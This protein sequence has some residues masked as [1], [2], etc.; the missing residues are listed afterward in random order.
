M[1]SASDCTLPRVR[2]VTLVRAR[3]ASRAGLKL[4]EH[5]EREREG[6]RFIQIAPVLSRDIHGT[7]CRIFERRGLAIEFAAAPTIQRCSV[8][9]CVALSPRVGRN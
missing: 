5:V 9:L 2:A 4:D 8:R 3:A 7:D 6:G 1:D